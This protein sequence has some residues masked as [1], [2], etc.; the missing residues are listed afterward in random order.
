MTEREKTQFR[1]EI[2][3]R[4]AIIE[5]DGGLTRKDAEHLARLEVTG[6]WQARTKDDQS[7]HA[8]ARLQ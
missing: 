6:Q 7:H 4:A 3:E 8:D 2:E 5:F 1:F